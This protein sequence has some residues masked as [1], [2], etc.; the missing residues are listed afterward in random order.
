M[1]EAL[2]A[3]AVMVN[4]EGHQFTRHTVSFHAPDPEDAGLLARQA[5]IEELDKRCAELARKLAAAEAA[6]ARAR[7]ALRLQTQALEQA[8]RHIAERQKGAARRADR[9]R[10]ALAGAGAL[11]ER[12]ARCTPSWTRFAPRPSATR[13]ALAEPARSPRRRVDRIGELARRPSARAKRS[14]ARRTLCG[15]AQRAAARR[16][17]SAGRA[18]GE[19]ECASKIAEID[20]AVRVIDQ[21]IARA[22]AE[23]CG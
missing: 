10:Q 7:R 2:A 4:R 13:Q 16:A 19:R 22:D 14:P 15:A 21:Q 17:R 11:R 23:V 5:E 12:S 20:N 8:R 9:E 3:G 18:F 1:R 6:D